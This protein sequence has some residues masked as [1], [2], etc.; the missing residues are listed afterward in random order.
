MTQGH[1]SIDTE[2][3]A[4]NDDLDTINGGNAGEILLI[5]P[6]NSTRMVRIRNGI[7]NIF[8]K[9][10]VD[11]HHLSFSS[12]SGAGDATRYSGGG[13]Y[14]WSTTDANLNQGSLTQT[15]GSSN[16]SYAAHASIVT[17]V[18]GTVDTGTVS[19]VVSGT[20]VD[21]EAN[22]QAGDS[23]TILA[24]ITTAGENGYY[25]TV[26]KCLGTITYTLT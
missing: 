3:N 8:L 21:D 24:D 16:V 11:S 26:K 14:D 13:Y 25:E 22:R 15:H 9:H 5:L 23:E 4:A 1:H 19:I 10:Q 12:P 18:N 20:S 17:R 7:G 2:G 6:N